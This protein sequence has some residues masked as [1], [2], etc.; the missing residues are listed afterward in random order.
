MD[1]LGCLAV[2]VFAVALLGFM[3]WDSYT[4]VP[5]DESDETYDV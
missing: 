2:F 1:G 4:P 5:D 3:L